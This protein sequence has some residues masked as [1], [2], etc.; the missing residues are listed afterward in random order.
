[1]A[2]PLSRPVRTRIAPSPTGDPH[3]GTAYMALFN[4]VFAQKHGGQFVIRIEDTDRSRYR[5]E[6]EQMILSSLQWLGLQ[7]DEGPDK[8]GPYGPYRQSERLPI[9]HSH[10]NTLL[11]KGHAYRCF[12]TAEHLDSMRK[13]RA[14]Q[15]LGGGYDRTCR[16]LSAEAIKDKLTQG[17]THTVR[18][19]VPTS[20][21][22][23]FEDA[24][25]GNVEFDN[26][27]IDDQVILKSDGFPTYHLAVVV[28]DH[29]MEISHVIRGEEWITSAPKHVILYEMFG[30][31]KPVFAHMPLLRNADK[32]KISKR[33]NPTSI[34]Y[35]KRKGILPEALRNFL[36][37]M[38][39]SL[40]GSTEIFSTEQM[41][42]SFS[43]EKLTL[44]GPV[45]DLTKLA[46][47]NGQYI[48]KMSDEEFVAHLKANIFS[49]SYLMEIAPLLRERI[50]K[51]EDFV[52]SASF[53]FSGDLAYKAAEML[54]K[55][56]TAPETAETIL[57]VMD[58]LEKLEEWNFTSIHDCFDR[59]L[60]EAGKK[61]KDVYMPFRVATTGSKETPPLMESL[62][63]LG[64]EIVRRR[65]RMAADFLKA[66]P[67]E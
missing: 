21:K 37:L 56:K 49:E 32:S 18:M 63:V 17:L 50:E 33:K 39:F 23:S 15:K 47:V 28:D 7:W 26:E 20:G 40:D 29:L 57:A 59:F 10:I 51:F 24:L 35:Y 12:C 42:E 65:V 30:W 3:I 4:S 11:E 27:T 62:A 67:L 64:K 55:G 2:T 14:E 8:P 22:T 61:A 25:R 31:E 60:K 13:Q 66:Q 6:S 44:G 43:L 54:P 45:F 53:F 1:M 5:K 58:E 41:V 48:R 19:K 16:G 9:Y 38:G 36:A 52:P 34:Q 46:W